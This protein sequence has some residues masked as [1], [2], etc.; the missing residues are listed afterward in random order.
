MNEERDRAAGAAGE[1]PQLDIAALRERAA[2]ESGKA[3]WRSLEDLAETPEFVEYLRHE[4][5]RQAA[6]LLPDVDRRSF[7]RLMGA[8]FA[9]AGLS[10]CTRQPPEEL[11]PYVR[12][13][14]QFVPGEPLYYATAMPLGGTGIGLLAESHLGRPTKLEGNPE[15]PASLGATDALAQASILGLY[16]PDRSKTINSAGEIRTWN[17]FQTAFRLALAAQK[18]KGGAGL[19]ILS[20]SISSPTAAAQLEEILAQYPQARWYQYAPV[21]RDGARA[22]AKAAFGAYVDA[23]YDF[24]RAD[25][26]LAIEADFLDCGHGHVRYAR[27]F[28]RRRRP[29]TPLAKGAPMNRLYA[30]EST[31]TNTGAAADHRLAL[32]PADVVELLAGVAA[33]LGLPAKPDEAAIRPHD[34]WL[35]AVVADL[36]KH[37][38]KSLVVAGDNQPAIV[39][40]LVFA[41]NRALGNVGATVRYIDP[42]EARPQEQTAS[43]ARLC[44]EI[45][46]GGVDVLLILGGNPVYDAPVD[47]RFRERL[48]KVP[49]RAHLSLYE[50]ETSRLCHWHVPETH[51]LESWSDVRAFDG[52][53]TIQQPLIAPLYDG[54]S[55]HEVLAAFSDQPA[56]TSYEIV[57]AHWQAA[58]G[59]GDFEAFWRK[60]VHDGVV[61]DTARAP[62]DVS[63][64]ADWGAIFAAAEQA[65]PDRSRRADSLDLLFAAD[66]TVHDGRF[67]NNAWL[68]ELPK[69]ITKLTWDNAALLAPATAER[70]GVRNGDVVEL[71][72]GDRRL[73]APA[74]IVPGHAPEAVTLHLGYGRTHAGKVGNGT[75][76]DAYALRLSTS[77][78]ATTGLE[79]RKTG[80]TR[81][82]ACTQNHSSM[83][84]R[85]IVRSA[86]LAEYEKDPHFHH[87]G[88]HAPGPKDSLYPPHPYD[89]YAWGLVIDLSSCTG[90]NA[91]VTACQAE[92]NIPVVG[93]EQV[94]NGREM[95]WIRVDR[96]YSGAL[97]NPE[98]HHQPVPC[99]HCENAPCEG[100]CPVNATVHSGEGLNDM[101]Y[102]RCVGTRYCANNCPYKVRRFN[103]LLYQNWTD[104]TLKMQR[105]PDVTVRSRGVMEKCTYCVQRINYSRIQANREGRKIR[106]GE[107]QTACQQACPAE[108]ITFGDIN[109]K[110]SAIARL[111]DEPRNYQL[112]ADLGTRPRTTYLAQIKNP[113]PELEGAA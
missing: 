112:L 12:Q 49:L 15:H 25:V 23:I 69:P 37:R 102:N 65:S 83:E 46:G 36:Q 9:L 61:A 79:I 94:E 51:Y 39:H 58:Q 33:R 1:A 17:A 62:R 113:N 92:N 21:N 43:L 72:L 73:E 26:V 98:T 85:D 16:D 78:W 103:F 19:R 108:A 10:A 20:E 28:A 88:T 41:I 77:P 57:R 111:R 7:L 87:V 90:C 104:E 53:A 101:V 82:L 6:G 70:L 110:A 3:Y 27:D 74:W 89:G 42:V 106:D 48:E 59:G 100:V 5:P 31:P 63:P 38:G 13:P 45:D 71:R 47:L 97:D 24:G 55:V 64:V 44:E 60:S 66:P 52:T 95:H 99:M 93:K 54:K 75:G 76:V 34:R 91:C 22:A 2:G 50:D 14:E 96:Y 109:D 4:F 80:E 68:Q 81:V 56:R 35:A 32:R 8:S 40:A 86:S 84:G 105:N 18:E 67:A 30:V 107:I 11:V 29:T